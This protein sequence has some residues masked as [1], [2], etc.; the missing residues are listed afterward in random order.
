MPT[1]KTKIVATISD[2]NCAVPFI[3]SLF[4]AGMNVARINTA[5]VSP[6]QAAQVVK[7]IREVS[8][9]IAILVDTK[10]PEIRL[11]DT[12]DGEGIALSKG[13]SIRFGGNP[14]ALSSA[15]ALYAN[16]AH[17]AEEVSVGAQI[18]ID[19]GDTALQVSGKDGAFLLCSVCENALIKGRKSINVPHASFLLPALSPKD[20]MFIEWAID[21]HIDFIA[22]SFVRN[23]ADVEAVQAILDQHQSPIKI[24]AKIENRQG[25]DN[26]DEILGVVYG[27]MVARGDLGVEIE[28]EKIPIIQRKIISACR[29][30]KKPVIIATQMLHTMMEHPRPTRA[31]VS[32]VA[33]AI[34]QR[35]DA[36]MLS[37]ETAN[38]KYPVESVKT[39]SRIAHEIESQLDPIHGRLDDVSEPVAAVLANAAVEAS[40]TLPIKAIVID[41]LS[42][43]TG[44]YLAAF[45]PR[46]PVYA[47][48]YKAHVARELSLSYG[49][50]ASLIDAHKSKD[51]FLKNAVESLLAQ[52]HFSP[53]ALVAVVGGS[54]GFSA[55][56]TFMEISPAKYLIGKE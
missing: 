16:Y 12:T 26:L 51:V 52:G 20:K 29:V 15:E 9:S 2:R 5:H 32:D 19:D 10:G 50:T 34:Y 35:T 25:V 44:R 39:M 1:K 24:I 4:D 41:T 53:D 36:I 37:G 11:T 54:F 13:Q 47:K 31:E 18:L 55:G 45:R 56:A 33:N 48:C 42:G 46:I 7:N 27:V 28:A 22:H 17:F 30:R 3:K 38:G 23:K 14:N 43:R 40:M 49:I 8:E 21:H 6:E